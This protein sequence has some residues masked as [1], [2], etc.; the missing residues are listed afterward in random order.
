MFGSR[1][2]PFNHPVLGQ[3]QQ[4]HNEVNRLFERWGEPGATAG[5][6]VEFPPLNV[7]QED[8]AFVVEADL[9]GLDLKDLEIYVTGHDQ[10]TLKGE[11]KAAVP[12][13]AVQ[14]RQERDFGAFAR[15]LTL[16]MDVD[17]DKVEA[18]LDNGVLRVRLPKSEAAKPRKI[19]IKA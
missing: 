15:T 9:P 12:A 3:L 1:F 10:L 16:P 11:R 13:K 4:L 6:A 8:D 19:E 14:H 17:A 7:W 2:T 5:R 18:R